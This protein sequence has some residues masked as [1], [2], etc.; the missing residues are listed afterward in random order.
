MPPPY[1]QEGLLK[2]IIHTN[3]PSPYYHFEYDT[4]G[5]IWKTA[6]L[7]GFRLYDITQKNDRITEIKNNTP[8]NKDR[9]EYEYDNG[10]RIVRI[11]I[12]D[13]NGTVYKRCY[14]AYTGNKLE[15]MD[16]ERKVAT[17]GFVAERFL[18][19]V[20]QTDGNLLEL[21]SHRPPFEGQTESK[22]T[23]RYE[24][25]D[26][27]TNVDGFS[28]VHEENEHLILLPG[29]QLQLH[30][31]GKVIRTGPGIN[32]TI[33]YTYTYNEKNVPLTKTGDAVFDN[34]PNAGTRFTTNT[35]FTYY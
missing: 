22:Y 18:S 6:F 15:K 8:V 27:K 24:Q 14:L 11:K 33:N 26:N 10:G 34:G 29:I 28:L 5:N 17:T 12:M 9:L 31:P 3:L 1:G 32:Y 21:T 7:S 30:N 4:K 35:A 2:D 25:Y 23:E 20:Y 13:Q 16:W 19:F